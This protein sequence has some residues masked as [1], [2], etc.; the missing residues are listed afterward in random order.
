MPYIELG[1]TAYSRAMIGMLLGS[2]VTFAIMYS[3]Q[4]L[5]SVFSEEY[6]IS[7]STASFTISL[8]TLALAVCLLF[9]SQ[10]ANAWGR[11]KVMSLSLVC[12]SLLAIASSFC[13]N[14]YLFLFLRFIEGI[15]VA[16]FPSVAIAYLNEEISPLSIGKVIGIYVAGTAIGG[17]MGRV[18][19]GGLTDL[20]SWHIAFFIL[21]LISLAFSLWFWLYLPESRNFK[22]TS[23]SFKSWQAQAKACLTN[24]NLRYVYAIGFVVM[25]IYI[26][27]LNYVGYLL[28]KEPYNLSQTIFGFLFAVNLIGT[29]SSILFG[30]LA[31]HHSRV[32]VTCLAITLLIAGALL[33]L[34]PAL[35]IKIIGITVFVFGFFASHSVASSWV[36][37]LAAKE[38]KAQASSLYLLFYYGGSSL[39]GWS[40]GIFLADFG[41]NGL[42]SYICTLALL[43]GFVLIQAKPS[44]SLSFE[45]S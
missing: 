19:I 23:F 4:P 30:K 16:G 14:F 42:I 25:G 18:V 9:V 1:S 44:L 38:I 13:P 35:L 34:H 31:D 3:P 40:G 6:H 29:W 10:F 45:K 37:L 26:A 41:W 12:T 36:G 2:I 27:L 22:Q 15:S 21:G 20:F 5:M 32:H 39:I 7:P 28:T 33:T 17:F 8:T 24:Q 11:K 43:L